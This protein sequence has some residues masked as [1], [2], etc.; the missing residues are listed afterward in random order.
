MAVTPVVPEVGSCGASGDLA[1]L[2]HI[3]LVLIGEGEAEFRGK[4][5]PGATRCEPPV[6]RPCNWRP[7]RGWR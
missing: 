4:V 2:A 3:A 6:G 1:P 5:M 7:R